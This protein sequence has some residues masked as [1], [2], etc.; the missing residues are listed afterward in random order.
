ML[1]NVLLD[2]IAIDDSPASHA[3]VLD[4]YHLAT[5]A[6]DRVA[7]LV[8]LNRSSEPSRRRILEK[9]YDE[10]HSHLSG[11]ANYLRIVSGGTRD[12]V[13]SMIEAEKQRPTFDITQPTWARALFLT[14]ATNNNMVWTDRG[15]AWLT[16]SIIELAP[17]NMTTTSRLLNTFQHARRMR[18]PLRENVLAS[19][20]R[21][22]ETLAEGEYPVIHNQASA[23]LGNSAE[24]K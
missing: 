15:I 16:N 22:V 4:H 2:L 11:Y 21:I 20:N 19:L 18:S 24:C 13:F 9:V 6:T 12:D 17:I 3:V 8:A 5:A 14:M 7:A 10:W 1:K 23:Y